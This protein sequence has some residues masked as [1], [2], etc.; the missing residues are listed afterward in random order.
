MTN[1]RGTNPKNVNRDLTEEERNLT[2]WLLENAEPEVPT[3]YLDQLDRASV[4]GTCTCG[5]A[6]F[7]L[8]IA[9]APPPNG[10][11]HVLGDF[12]FGDTENLCGIFVFER[13]GFL[14]GVEVTGYAVDAPHSLPSPTELR[15]YG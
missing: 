1:D 15:P 10:G 8:K 11:M 5:C 9:G 3:D 2:R 4:C 12:L 7:D 13:G 6:S 14:A